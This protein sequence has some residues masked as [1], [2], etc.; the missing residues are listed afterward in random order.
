[1]ETPQKDSAEWT[2]PVGTLRYFG[3]PMCSWCWGLKPVLEQVDREYPELKRI[4]VMGGLRGGR[5]VPM[6]DGLAGMIQQAWLRIEET[7][8]QSFNHTLWD[9]KRPLATTWPA[10]RAVIAA[11][12][13]DPVREWPYMVGMFQA[14]FTRALDPSQRATHLTVAAEQGFD[15]EEFSVA[16]EAPAVEEAL[17]ED[18]RTT[19]RFGVTGFPSVVLTV[20]DQHYLVAPGYQPIEA[21][22]KAINAAYQTAGIEFTRPE[23]GVY[24]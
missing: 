19:Q 3:D 9:S 22:R 10:C 18:L 14:Y 21:V 6:T 1:M 4:T 20:A 7:T 12:Q 16:L 24:S 15:P 23:S 17:Q 8:G 2:E 13:L 5:E 11:R